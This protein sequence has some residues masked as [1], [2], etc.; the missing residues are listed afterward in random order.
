MH[1][2]PTFAWHHLLLRRDGVESS[3]GPWI[4]G[5]DESAPYA[6]PPIRGVVERGREGQPIRR[7]VGVG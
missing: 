3:S 7:V 5:A 4:Q 6:G 1:P 2:C